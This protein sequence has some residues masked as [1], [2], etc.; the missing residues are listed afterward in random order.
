M[1]VAMLTCVYGEQWRDDAE[2]GG[3]EIV[4]IQQEN[5]GE[6]TFIYIHRTRVLHHT[7]MWFVVA[8][9]RYVTGILSVGPQT[10][11][12]VTGLVGDSCM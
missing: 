2:I 7:N 5:S 10:P 1:A 11:R 9:K 8:M 6:R 4:E 12:S 3:H